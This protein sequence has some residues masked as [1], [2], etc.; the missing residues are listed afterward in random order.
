MHSEKLLGIEIEPLKDSLVPFMSNWVA[1]SEVLYSSKLT[2]TDIHSMMAFELR[3]YG[4]QHIMQRLISRYTKLKSLELKD[5]LAK[6]T[7]LWEN[8]KKQLRII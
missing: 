2:S 1:L 3:H 6:E 4:R 7:M 8:Q 5:Q